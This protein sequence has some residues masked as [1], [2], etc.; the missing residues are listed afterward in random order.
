M[1]AI[2]KK[3][4]EG[5]SGASSDSTFDHPYHQNKLSFGFQF[6]GADGELGNPS[7]DRGDLPKI[8]QRPGHKYNSDIESANTSAP[9]DSNEIISSMHIADKG[10]VGLSFN[11]E[12]SYLEK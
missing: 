5:E 7:E 6:S 4:F 9:I 2:P 3:E 10:S 12:D 11:D 1:K 8:L